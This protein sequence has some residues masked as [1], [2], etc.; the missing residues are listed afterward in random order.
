MKGLVVSI[1]LILVPQVSVRSQ[2]GVEDTRW[3]RMAVGQHWGRHIVVEIVEID[4]VDAISNALPEYP[5]AQ[6]CGGAIVWSSQLPTGRY[7]VGMTGGPGISYAYLNCPYEY[8][9]AL[10]PRVDDPCIGEYGGLSGLASPS[11][12][13]SYFIFRSEGAGPYDDIGFYIIDSHCL[14]NDGYIEIT[15]ARLS[16]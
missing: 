12:P 10:K 9:L 16:D 13:L 2:C 3:N 7:V 14:D 8:R 6:G 5:G 1:A 15:I 4:T 11:E